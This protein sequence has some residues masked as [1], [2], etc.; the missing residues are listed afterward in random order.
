MEQSTQIGSP[1]VDN[2][3]QEPTKEFNKLL[4]NTLKITI[5]AFGIINWVTKE[6]WP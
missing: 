3:Y 1:N 4:L 6:G 5:N 2:E